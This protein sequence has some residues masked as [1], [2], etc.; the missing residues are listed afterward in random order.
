MKKK[1]GLYAIAVGFI[2]TLFGAGGGMIAVPMLKKLGLE[3]KQSQATTICIIL[4]LT[5]ISCTI[6]LL[7]GF[8]TFSD[9]VPYI[10]P[11]LCGCVLGTAVFKKL[12][13]KFLKRAFALFMLWAGIRL[14]TK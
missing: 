10:L 1:A 9:S 2:N 3:Q 8:V 6:Y 4:P 7:K 5:V 12:S 11:G 13:N 14:I